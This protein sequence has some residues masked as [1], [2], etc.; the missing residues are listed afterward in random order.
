MSKYSIS[1]TFKSVDKMSK[2]IAK[3]QS[4]VSKFTVGAEAGFRKL[5]AATSSV[6]RGLGKMAKGF[7]TG[8]AGIGA[9][10]IGAS[11]VINKQQTEI[12]NL[13]KAVNGS[14][15]TVEA[16][17]S[18]IASSGL[19][20][21][22]VIDLYEEMNNKLGESAGLEEITAVTESLGILGLRFRDIQKLSPEEQFKAITNAALKMEDATKAQ[23]AADI[24][25]GGEANKI[26]GILR[27]QG[28]SMDDIIGNYEKL[29]FRT[30]ESRQGA[31]DQAAS[32]G[33]TMKIFASLS[34]EIAGLT[35]K[36]LAPMIDKFNKFVITNKELIG[37]SID[38]FFKKVS[39]SV[40]DV[41]EV[42]EKAVKWLVDLNA[43]F[44][45]F[46]KWG[47]IIAKVTGIVVAL[48]VALQG[49]IAVLTVINMVMAANP[50]TLIVLGI[51]AALGLLAA[52][53]IYVKDNWDSIVSYFSG[54][55]DSI[56]TTFSIGFEFVKSAFAWSP[57]GMI[58]ENWSGITDYFTDLFSGI[59]DI[60]ER[61][62]GKV[63]SGIQSAKSFL[64]L[65]DD[66]V[67]VNANGSGSI[68]A[69][70]VV[71]PQE[72]ISRE[73]S[74]YRETFDIN[75][76]ADQGSSVYSYGN[77]PRVKLINTGD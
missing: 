49:I 25:M 14:I 23:A 58:I 31:R 57:M 22:S 76:R 44:E 27:S 48:S 3:M 37:Q 11:T 69:A 72:R 26:I 56:K 19:E 18:A 21:E 29:S 74:D 77:N 66:D 36:Y 20:A 28:K 13:T 53:V 45:Q 70:N 55:W 51:V 30:E 60:Y 75:V 42:F 32:V 2:P 12:E 63:M 17:S 62:V 67:E 41:S 35:G 46:K 68:D 54:V 5:D 15:E 43:N 38:K 9:T 34:K 50:V 61:T 24:L 39:D 8:V 52:A 16:V 33:E 47:A 59:T 4:Q 6:S 73:I 71:T 40:G 7:A 10:V 64:G 65:G 1:T